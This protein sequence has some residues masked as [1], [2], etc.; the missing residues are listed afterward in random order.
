MGVVRCVNQGEDHPMV[1]LTEDDVRLI[2]KAWKGDALNQHARG[3]GLSLSELAK[4][5]EVDWSTIW[6]IVQYKTWPHV[7]DEPRGT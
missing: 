2:R 5:F 3:D 7:R 4:K 1:K 6:K